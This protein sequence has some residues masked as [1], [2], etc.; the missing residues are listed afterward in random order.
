MQS[1]INKGLESAQRVIEAE[2]HNKVLV[3]PVPSIKSYFLFVAIL[4]VDIIKRSDNVELT[5]E[6]S[7]SQFI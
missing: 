5:K 1:T 2:G 7:L 6:L 3:L 4:N